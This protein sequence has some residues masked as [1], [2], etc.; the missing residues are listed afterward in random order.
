MANS[1]GRRDRESAQDDD[2]EAAKSTSC[3]EN[4]FPC[5][6]SSQATTESIQ[7]TA[8]RE[9]RASQD[10]HESVYRT[11]V[12]NMVGLDPD[13]LRAIKE[14]EDAYEAM[15]T[16]SHHNDRQSS[17]YLDASAGV[18]DDWAYLEKYMPATTANRHER[19]SVAMTNP[20]T[21]LAI[22]MPEFR[23]HKASV[24]RHRLSSIIGVLQHPAVKINTPGYPG[25]LTE[26]EVAACLQ[27]REELEKRGDDADLKN[28]KCYRE[29]VDAFH[30]V[31]EEPYALC[32]FLR[33]RKFDVDA[34]MAML[35]DGVDVWAEGKKHNFFPD[36]DEAIGN[37]IS[38]LRTQY[39]MIYE[40]IAKN[41]CPVSYFK[42]GQISV[43]GL[44]C[45][46][47]LSRLSNLAWYQMMTTFP[48][49]I[50]KAQASNADAVRCESVAV[51]DLKGLKASSLNARTLEVMKKMA[52]VSLFLCAQFLCTI[53]IYFLNLT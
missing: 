35:D 46:T 9:K 38:V 1:S 40:G 34:V 26:E 25:E 47:I 19:G 4:L 2:D 48:K 36:V 29:M 41:D 14:F 42:A 11:A 44:E 20:D 50:A 53:I 21:L 8:R 52:A 3:L 43:D 6:L 15:I 18:K 31:E 23:D 22:A 17:I 12:E 51:I 7:V 16:R 28:G 27:F 33:A 32:R 10:Q 45:V 37:P 39:P 49:Q 30:S 13:E 24:V 5:C